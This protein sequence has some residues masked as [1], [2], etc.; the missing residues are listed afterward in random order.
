MWKQLGVSGTQKLTSNNV[1]VVPHVASASVVTGTKM[2]LMA[3]NNLIVG[4]KG[5]MSLNP[6]NPE[7]L[8]KRW[9][10]RMGY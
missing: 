4:L 8:K 9:W 6:V 5:E 3:A 10:A 1:I 7:V 2:G